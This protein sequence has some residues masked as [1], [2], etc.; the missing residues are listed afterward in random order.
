M[1]KKKTPKNYNQFLRALKLVEKLRK[2][3]PKVSIISNCYI[4]FT[5]LKEKDCILNV[6]N[7]NLLKNNPTAIIQKGRYFNS[8]KKFIVFNNNTLVDKTN[9]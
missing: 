9:L 1:K 5:N 4:D 6:T 3:C 8:S 2:E 7:F